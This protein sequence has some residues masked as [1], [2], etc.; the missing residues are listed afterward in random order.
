MRSLRLIIILILAII[1]IS[2][3]WPKF[4]KPP[5]T[6]IPS[7][8]LGPYLGYGLAIHGSDVNFPKAFDD[9]APQFVRMEFGPRWDHLSEKIPTGKTVQDYY[10]YLER[11]YNGDSPERLTGARDSH[12]F[13]RHRNI[14]II[15]IHF[16]LPH[17]WRAKDNSDRFLSQHIQDLARFH[18]AH[19]KFLRNNGIKIDYMELVN[20]PDGNWNGHIPAPD[21]ARLLQLCDSLFEKHG[22]Q[23]VKILGPGLAFLNLYN[24]QTPYFEE[25]EKVGIDNL[26]GWSTHVWDEAEF[27]SSEPEYTYGIWQPFLDTIN[28][29]DPEKTKPIF[30]TEYASDITK[31][32]DKEWPSPRDQVENTVTDTWHNAVRVIAN[33]VT[34][35]NRGANA[36]VVY[37]LSDTHWHKTDWGMIESTKPPH[38][39]IKPVY[40][41]VSHALKSLPVNGNIL[42]PLWHQND[43]LITLS[44]IHQTSDNSFHLLIV[45]SHEKTQ[46]TTINL[47]PEMQSASISD[48]STMIKSGLTDTANI[49]IKDTTLNIKMP[50]LSISR[51]K[52]QAKK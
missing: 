39:E 8:T 34:H 24:K 2:F 52:L 3:F 43:A 46:T 37:R 20:E 22:L 36:L 26:D 29:I 40:H 15:K 32:G 50:P 5:A 1:A 35:L 41:A 30:V 48:I 10:H 25:I 42:A 23:D 31:F 4:N 11:N 28:K 27:T 38:F 6:I 18:T 7:Q 9:L 33:S 47:N 16:E 19:L 12:E 21:Y 13:L 17:Y 44:I 51:V 49:S 14:Q 45:N